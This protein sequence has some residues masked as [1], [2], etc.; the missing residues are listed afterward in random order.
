MR[1]RDLIALA[2]AWPLA[3][4]AQQKAK[5]VIG[6]LFFGQPGTIPPAYLPA[7]RQGLRETGYVE[8][9][10]LT[11]E[12]RWGEGHG[13][14]LPAL[15]ADLVARKV[16]LIVTGVASTTKKATSTIPIVFTSFGGDPV[17]AGLVAGLARPGGNI[18][19]FTD[20]SVDLGAKRVE[21]LSELVP[22]ADTIALLVNRN[23]RVNAERNTRVTQEAAQ[24]MGRRLLILK[25]GTEGEIEP[26]FQSLAGLRVGAIVIAAD[27]FFFV[28]RKLLVSLASRYAVPAIYNW[29]ECPLA[30]G[31]ISYGID[32]AANWRQV[33]IYAGRILNGEK[34]ADLPVQQP[35]KFA[36]VI[37]L[38]T[39]QALGLTVPQSL[40]ARADEVIE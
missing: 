37:N 38:K 9:Q 18:T 12:Y 16:D 34:P 35:T 17:K 23:N 6:S 4:R 22:Q 24:A 13:D 11:I 29:R 20:V 31:L 15:A 33:G 1:R 14:R 8:G 30:G 25:A 27:L 28:R 21:L 26:A 40:L 10:N 36:L 7:L 32:F 19:G 3:A 2:A 39:A 5:R